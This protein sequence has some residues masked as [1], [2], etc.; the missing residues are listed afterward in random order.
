MNIENLEKFVEDKVCMSINTNMCIRSYV[1]IWIGKQTAKLIHI[2][3]CEYSYQN[4]R[5]KKTEIAQV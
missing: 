3:M 4:N 5:T 2:Y 1:S